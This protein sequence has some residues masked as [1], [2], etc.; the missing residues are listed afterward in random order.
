V[1]GTRDDAKMKPAS[2]LAGR[3][4]SSVISWG[5]HTA[6]APPFLLVLGLVRRNSRGPATDS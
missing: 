2:D 1:V 6:H 4:S 3:E 5:S